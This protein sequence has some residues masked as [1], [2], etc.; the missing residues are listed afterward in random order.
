MKVASQRRRAF[1]GVIVI[2]VAAV[3]L[4]S[5]VAAYYYSQ[6]NQV[7]SENRTYVQQL[8]QLGV[9]YSSHILIDFGNGTKTWYNDTKFQP[10][11][12]VYVATQ[13]ITDGHINATY[14][15]PPYSEHLITAIYNVAEVG[16]DYWG[17]WTYNA[18]SSWQMAQ[19]G[20]DDL[21]VYNGS[22]Y[23]WAFGT[24]LAPP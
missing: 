6:Y 18:T 10:G 7:E 22:V 8:K 12:D 20:A 16:T 4:T 19:V 13:V 23:A 3:L 15:P 11:W 17:L 1:L 24:N 5:A 14:Y 2:L 9:E 21:K